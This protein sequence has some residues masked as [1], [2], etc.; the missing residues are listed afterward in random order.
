MKCPAAE[1]VGVG[2]LWNV[3]D[4]QHAHRADH[5]VEFAG[6][7][8]FAGERPPLIGIR[9]PQR[10]D[11][12][13]RDEM[14]GQT[15]VVDDLLDVREDLGLLGEGLAPARVQRERVGVEVRRHVARRAGVGVLAPGPAEVVAAVEDGEVISA[16]GEL[17]AHRD[18]AKTSADD[19]HRRFVRRCGHRKEF[20]AV[21]PRSGKAPSAKV[22]ALP[23]P[24]PPPT[25]SSTCTSRSRSWCS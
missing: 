10:R 7:A 15:M 4:V 8:V 21:S 25:G 2:D 18:P 13:A 19:C 1:S 11:T 5:D 3:R 14:L 24:V 9:P 6:L 23:K 22:S 17:D 20:S 12:R 16:A